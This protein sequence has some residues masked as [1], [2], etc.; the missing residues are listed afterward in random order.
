MTSGF[1][2]ALELLGAASDIVGNDALLICFAIIAVSCMAPL[3]RVILERL[4]VDL[5]SSIVTVG[6]SY[7][8][9]DGASVVIGFGTITVP[10]ALHTIIPAVVM[11]IPP[12]L[13]DKMQLDLH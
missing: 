4:H 1:V 10:G 12:R 3:T 9:R 6:S 7:N 2:R 8:L 5:Q 11:L 13:V